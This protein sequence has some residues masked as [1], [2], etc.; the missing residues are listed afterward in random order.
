VS[1]PTIS[2]PTTGEITAGNIEIS[3]SATVNST[4]ELLQN[5]HSIRTINVDNHGNWKTNIDIKEVGR[6]QII[7]QAMDV[8]GKVLASNKLLLTIPEAISTIIPVI[9]MPSNGEIKSTTFDIS[10]TASPNSTLE[11]LRDNSVIGKVDVNS[12]GHWKINTTLTDVGKYTYIVQTMTGKGKQALQSNPLVLAMTNQDSDQDGIGN[13]TDLCPN[14]ATGTVVDKLGCRHA[15][16]IILDGVN[17]KTNSAKLTHKSLA[18]LDQ[19]VNA[20]SKIPKMQLEISGHTDSD[21]GEASNLNLSQRRA[22][23][24]LAYLKSHGVDISEMTAKGYGE[25]KAIANNSTAEGKAKNRRVELNR[26]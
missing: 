13:K 24:T 3:G 7:A 14:S 1:I 25:S 12:R 5:N 9:T 4:I 19:V 26:Q 18:I 2:S 11:L 10:G 6:Y 8:N 21:G 17:F 15:K 16:A 20:L 23:A 22:E